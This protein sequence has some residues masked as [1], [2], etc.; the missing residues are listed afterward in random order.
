MQELIIYLLKSA[1]LMSLFYAGYFF[2]LKNDTGFKANRFFL[3]AGIV[4]SL[5]LPSLEITR[6]IAVEAAAEPFLPENFSAEIFSTPAAQPEAIDWWQIAG[7]VYLAGLAFFL[8]KFFLELFF[9]LKLIVTHKTIKNDEVYLIHQPG[10]SQPFSFFK[11]VIVDPA[12]HTPT[13][14]DLILKH[15]R[16]HV[17]QWHSVDQLLSSLCVA[18]LWFNPLCWLYRKSLV[19]NLEYLADREVMQ[20]R[21]SKKQYQTTLLKISVGNF[22]P[23]LTNNF[24][25]SF[26]KKRIMMLN[27]N[28][29]EKSHFWKVSLLL[30]FL[31]LFI[32]LFNVRTVAQV[33]DENST[34]N[35]VTSEVEISATIHKN[36]TKGSLSQLEKLF[37]KR[38]VDLQFE[39]LE[40]SGEGL[41]TAITVSHHN[42]ATGES[43]SIS[44]NDPQGI[45]PTVIYMND[46]E[47][48]FR[49][50]EEPAAEKKPVLSELGNEP[51]FI[52]AGKEHSAKNLLGKK[53]HVTG[54]MNILNPEEAKTRLG[55]KAE[56][57]AVIISEGLVVDEIKE[58]LKQMD[59]QKRPSK[60][61]FIEV[62][63]DS[64]PILMSASMSFED[65]NAPKDL[66]FDANDFQWQSNSDDIPAIHR[67]NEEMKNMNFQER[68]PLIVVDGERKAK[69]F[70]VSAI[71]PSAI[72]SLNVL[73]DQN[74]VDKYGEAAKD[75]A[76]EIELKTAE[77]MEDSSEETKGSKE[78]TGKINFSAHSIRFEDNKKLS[79]RDVG[80]ADPDASKPLYVIDGKV[81]K[82]DFDPNSIAPDDI[83]SITVL[84]DAKATEKYGEKARDGVIEIITKK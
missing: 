67:E 43:G 79:V 35:H 71:D 84:K 7:I 65:S 70:N 23:A 30:P 83:E 9:L 16:A 38:G 29:S 6:T 24:Y 25:Q 56:D 81:L 31:C 8:L 37:K 63:K 54:E 5:L 41:L 47:T 49:Q 11:F 27:K 19:Q 59:L 69:D 33:V 39:N 77:E 51:L 61:T 12:Q 53:I 26:I 36:T 14:L 60:F 73:K 22:Q 10:N 74:A 28:T 78:G 50:G 21:V 3:L 15:E 75:G 40:Y 46:R 1:G 82:N 58:I 57:G 17:K 76:I 4:T 62:R 13:E 55:K 18:L 44:L 66:G 52:I 2:L 64:A 42:S 72:K 34:G 68:K 45:K 20:A 48:G 80:S 32:F